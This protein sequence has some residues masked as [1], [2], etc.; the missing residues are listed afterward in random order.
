MSLDAI[1]ADEIRPFHPAEASFLPTKSASIMQ[2]I[3]LHTWTSSYSSTGNIAPY[4]IQPE[5]G[6]TACSSVI[7]SQSSLLTYKTTQ[8]EVD[9]LDATRSHRRHFYR[10][11]RRSSYEI[12]RDVSRLPRSRRGLKSTLQAIFRSSRESSSSGSNITLPMPR[13]AAARDAE[14]N[15]SMREFDMGALRRVKRQKEQNDLKKGTCMGDIEG[16][17]EH[18]FMHDLVQE[19]VTV[20]TS[21]VDEDSDCSNSDYSVYTSM[22]EGSEIEVEGGVALT[23]E[24]V[25]THTPDLVNISSP[26]LVDELDDKQADLNGVMTQV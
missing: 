17:P 21:P 16:I 22:S 15:V 2:D 12:A 1:F 9:S 20:R 10:M 4:L 18:P 24:A 14:N 25:E 3:G 7:S 13:T 6:A 26:G 11:G 23:E 5:N 19:T 8:S